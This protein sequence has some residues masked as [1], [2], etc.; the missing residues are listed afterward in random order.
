[1]PLS[2]DAV[3]TSISFSVESTSDFLRYFLPKLINIGFRLEDI[4]GNEGFGGL[5]EDIVPRFRQAGAHIE[6]A[7]GPG[8]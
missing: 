2:R 1:M 3:L 5:L 4:F 8:L 6:N 7:I